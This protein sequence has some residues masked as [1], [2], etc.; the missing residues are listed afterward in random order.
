[1]RKSN[2][3]KTNIVNELEIVYLVQVNSYT[4]Y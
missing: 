1:M 2:P 4:K 3:M